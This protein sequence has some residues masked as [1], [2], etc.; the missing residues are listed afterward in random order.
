MG[1]PRGP[2]SRIGGRAHPF[3]APPREA[4][5]ASAC[6]TMDVWGGDSDLSVTG[7]AACMIGNGETIC[8][9]SLARLGTIDSSAA[10]ALANDPCL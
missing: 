9:P 6:Q 10:C 7:S 3:G 1:P 4:R 5:I 8:D 2:C